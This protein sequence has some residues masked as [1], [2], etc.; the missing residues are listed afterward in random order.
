M[1]KL[2][3][4]SAEVATAL[5]MLDRTAQL[6]IIEEVMG[7]H[8]VCRKMLEATGR[9]PAPKAPP[10]AFIVHD[11]NEGI[12]QSPVLRRVS[13]P[14]IDTIIIPA[15]RRLQR[16]HAFV[17]NKKFDDDTLKTESDT[18]M[19]QSG[20]LGHPLYYDLRW[21]ELH[22]EKCE[23]ADAR[24][25]FRHMK[26][27]FFF[28]CNTPY[29]RI[30]GA[31]WRPLLDVPSDSVHP[32]DSVPEETAKAVVDEIERRG[33]FWPHYWSAIGDPQGFRRISPTESFR[34]E[35]EF[36]EP[37]LLHAPI[38]LKVAMQDTLYAN[39]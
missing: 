7:D 15:G 20:Q 23:A 37:V 19:Y 33:G 17:D 30:V 8:S 13:H 11:G 32:R 3:G 29:Q 35:L 26:F 36:S 4:L 5:A 18:N 34:A 9:A 6:Q 38:Q 10:P 24:L 21:L 31:A 14:L 16:Y 28:G 22:F 2:E 39:L 1:P 25:I 12:P 27:T